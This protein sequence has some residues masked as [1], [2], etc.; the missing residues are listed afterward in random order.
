MKKAIEKINQAV[1]VVNTFAPLLAAITAG[2]AAFTSTWQ[3]HKTP[4]K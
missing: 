3:E 1:E 4:K 2:M